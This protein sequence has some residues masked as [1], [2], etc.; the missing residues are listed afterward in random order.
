M[1][2]GLVQLA[3]GPERCCGVIVSNTH[4]LTSRHQLRGATSGL[5]DDG[6]PHGRYPVRVVAEHPEADLAVVATAIAHP[7]W[8]PQS[9]GGG[10]EPPVGAHVEVTGFSA[11]PWS[12][13]AFCLPGDAAAGTFVVECQPLGSRW[14]PCIGDSGSPARWNGTVIGICSG[15]V[16]H[17]PGCDGPQMRYVFIDEER[18]AWIAQAT[19]KRYD[20]APLDALASRRRAVAVSLG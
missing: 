4:V 5:V 11:G 2:A 18:A 17:T 8:P 16:R 15:P 14:L 20:P 13:R 3:F 19:T 1:R 9:C 10:T 6:T 7:S 12:A